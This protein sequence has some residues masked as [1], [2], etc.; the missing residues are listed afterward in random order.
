M[1]FGTNANNRKEYQKVRNCIKQKIAI[2]CSLINVP[3]RDFLDHFLQ[4]GKVFRKYF[5]G[6]DRG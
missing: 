4:K 5:R 2:N 1:P 3:N 6:Y